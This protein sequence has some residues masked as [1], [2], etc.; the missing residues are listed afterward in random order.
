MT[1]LRTP[2]L[3]TVAFFQIVLLPSAGAHPGRAQDSTPPIATP[4]TGTGAGATPATGTGPIVELA[5]VIALADPS[6]GIAF[7]PGGNIH[8]IGPLGDRI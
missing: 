6:S 2:R 4:G 8:A 3:L 7:D 1:A 5:G